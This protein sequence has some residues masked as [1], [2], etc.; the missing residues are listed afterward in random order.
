ML[1][2]PIADC[3][4]LTSV[5]ATKCLSV[6]RSITRCIISNALFMSSTLGRTPLFRM[7][8]PVGYSSIGSVNVSLKGDI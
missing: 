1:P 5:T 8:N 3:H 2:P 4:S 7:Y 6:A